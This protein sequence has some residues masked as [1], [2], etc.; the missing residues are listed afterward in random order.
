M[1]I[2]PLPKTLSIG[3]IKGLKRFPDDRFALQILNVNR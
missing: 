2:M 3:A 1:R